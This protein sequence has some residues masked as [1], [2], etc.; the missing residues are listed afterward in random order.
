MPYKDPERKRQ[1]E[2]EHREQRN[3]RRRTR[4][5]SIPLDLPREAGIPD[6]IAEQKADT[7]AMIAALVV[8]VFVL[9]LFFATWRLRRKVS[10]TERAYP[11]H[12]L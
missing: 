11:G 1:W 12:A 5:Q 8:G 7:G 2:R 9:G 4:S 10:G 3:T 6:L